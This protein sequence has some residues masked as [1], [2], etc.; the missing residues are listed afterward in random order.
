MKPIKFNG[1]NNV[2]I[3]QDKTEIPCLKIKETKGRV[4][5]CWRISLFDWFRITFTGNVWL[6]VMTYNGY[7]PA[8][9]TTR[10]KD[11]FLIEGSDTATRQQ[12]KLEALATKYKVD[13]NSVIDIYERFEV[14]KR[15]AYENIF[16][17]VEKEIQKVMN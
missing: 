6:G 2:T 7:A 11:L 15:D 12:K 9:I 10:R 4:I 3:N 5:T 14:G 17:K 8:R 16:E 13:L 1:H